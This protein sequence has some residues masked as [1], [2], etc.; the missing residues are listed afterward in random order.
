M[1]VFF[2]ADTHFSDPY[3]LRRRVRFT[4]A[5]EHDEALIARWN[6]TV[7]PEDEVWHLGDFAAGASRARCAEIHARL[8]GIKRL[9]RGNHDTN[10]VLNLSWT[11]PPPESARIAVRDDSGSEHSLYLAHYA[12]RSWPGLWRGVRHLYGHTH[13]ALLDTRRSCDVG[14]DAWNYQPVA[15]AAVI[16]RQDAA[17]AWP[18]ELARA[19]NRRSGD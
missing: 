13:G 15:L 4:S 1:A 10:R 7:G 9:I 8:N 6:D 5:G 16:A 17:E 14:V 19:A 3:I 12:H 11:D 2:T 18:E